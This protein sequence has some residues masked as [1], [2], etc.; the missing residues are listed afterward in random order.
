[1]SSLAN[2]LLSITEDEASSHTESE[3]TILSEEDY[4]T[5][6]DPPEDGPG[7]VSWE[8]EQNNQL[9]L[10]PGAFCCGLDIAD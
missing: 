8:V 10:H 3:F 2:L 9:G 4:A 6:G 5:N 1:M 7:S